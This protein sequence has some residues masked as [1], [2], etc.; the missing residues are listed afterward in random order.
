[1]PTILRDQDIPFPPDYTTIFFTF[2][3][4]LGRRPLTLSTSLLLRLSIRLPTHYA[5][6]LAV[7]LIANPLR[8]R[9]LQLVLW[10][11]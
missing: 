10:S 1:M 5:W 11:A 9:I 3:F 8:C 2:T 4:T 7:P 6:T